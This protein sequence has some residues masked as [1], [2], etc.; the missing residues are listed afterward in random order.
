M[1]PGAP[2]ASA[3]AK[4]SYAP[5]KWSIWESNPSVILLAKQ[6]TTPGSPIP[7]TAV[8]PVFKD[9]SAH[10]TDLGLLAAPSRVEREHTG[11]KPAALPLRYEAIKLGLAASLGFE[12]KL[13]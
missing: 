12:P 9:L 10:R 8:T 5:I 7:Q 13:F 1:R 6:T 11:S 2:K 4:L 3:L